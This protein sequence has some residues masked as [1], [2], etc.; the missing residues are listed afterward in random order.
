MNKILLLVAVCSCVLT[1]FSQSL[2]TDDTIF[3]K[4]GIYKTFD[5]FRH[6]SPSIPM[7]YEV[8]WGKI[9]YGGLEGIYND[10]LYN[11]KIDKTKAKQIGNV[12]GFCDG[13]NI[14]INMQAS[15]KRSKVTGNSVKVFKPIS[16]FDKLFYLGRYC[17]FTTGQYGGSGGVFP[18]HW[19]CALDFNTGKELFLD[20]VA[21]K[22][23]LEKDEELLQAYK[24]ENKFGRDDEAYY[25]FLQLY[26]EKHKDE[27]IR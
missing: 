12:W 18:H 4:K 21:M 26:S 24:D 22:K 19:V 13:K 23:I 6:N 2:I 15:M 11:L 16:Q 3:L 9:M 14:Y 1:T 25:K 20:R 7:E 8:L 27:I 17:Y 10:T 5:E